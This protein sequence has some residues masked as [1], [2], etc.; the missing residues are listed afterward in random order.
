[1]KNEKIVPGLILVGIGTLF[2]LDNYNVIDFHWSNLWHLW[3]VFLIMG[4]VNLVLANNKAVW[5]TI[6][7]ISVVVLCFG[8]LIFARTENHWSS[9]DNYNFHYNDDDDDDDSDTTQR[10]SGIVKIEGNSTFTEPFNAAVT[11]AKLNVSGGGTVYKLQDTTS[12]LFDATTKEFYNKYEYT[13]TMDGTTPVLNLRMKKNNGGHFDFGD[14]KGNTANIKLN[15]RPEWEVNIDAG[16]TELDFDLSPYKIRNLTI[17]GGA[18]SFHVKLGQ[19][20]ASTV[21]E[22]KTGVSE[23]LIKV[24][25]NAACRITSDSGLSSSTFDGFD[26]KD[27]NSYQTPG[28]D[29]AKNKIEIH[30]KGGL[31]DFKVQKY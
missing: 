1:M 31:S 3:P 27:D 6:V 28:F 17:N 10:G 14:K 2:L 4:G 15:T 25:A 21:V 30:M 16:A 29:A 19:P 7:K 9:W 18:A 20:I 22:V 24:P 26:K 23:V 5:A 13:K 8:V 12:N 11:F